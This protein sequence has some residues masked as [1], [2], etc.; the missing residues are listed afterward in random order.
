[1][2]DS[3]AIRVE[4][5]SK[6]YRLG[7]SATDRLTER[8]QNACLATV[9]T[10]WQWLRRG[11]S[12]TAV[13]TPTNTDFWALDDVSFD[14]ERGETLGIIGRNGAGKSTLLKI[15]TRITEPTRGRFGIRG[16][17][18]SLLEVG[19]GFHPDLTGRENIYLSGSLLGLSR[20][21]IRRR[22]DEIVA[23]AEIDQF[24]DTPVKRYSSGMYTRLGFAVAAHL[25]SEV[26]IVDE[27][28]AVGDAQ[29]QKKCLGKMHD[30]AVAGR[31]VLFV[32]HN[33][34]AVQNLCSQCL[35]L[36]SG[37]A[38]DLGATLNV[39][40]Q[41]LARDHRSLQGRTA[42][43]SDPTRAPADDVVR[44]TRVA[45]APADT[46]PAA[47]ILR[48]SPIAIEVEFEILRPDH[49]PA[50]T[51]HLL[52]TAGV[53]ALGA[54]SGDSD[55]PIAVSPGRYRWR[56]TIPG[57]WLNADHYRLN[58]LL[59]EHGRVLV[60]AEQVVQFEI[61]EQPRGDLGWQGRRLGVVRPTLSWTCERVSATA[62]TG[63]A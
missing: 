27:V 57:G 34:I 35:W 25:E 10:P 60:S 13:S 2:S 40:R 19:T 18:A 49:A 33:M 32:S 17:V 55:S 48:E 63:A 28:L 58:V 41:Y 4:H 44:L 24:I 38:R 7:P 21:E 42:V 39:T 14:V 47:D 61:V 6:R 46:D 31:T 59:V 56:T 62:T 11:S 45:V 36:E 8:L 54:T 26:L 20:Q 9:R 16:R 3:L 50:V 5:L 29:F 15:L 37:R 51:M 53:P 52:T 22:F 23:F 1:M 12:S 30:V 43:W